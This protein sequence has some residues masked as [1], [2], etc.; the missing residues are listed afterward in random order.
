MGNQTENEGLR[1]ELFSSEGRCSYRVSMCFSSWLRKSDLV[2]L[3][4]MDNGSFVIIKWI[5]N[6]LLRSVEIT[7]I[8]TLRSRKLKDWSKVNWKA[9]HL[10]QKC[11]FNSVNILLSPWLLSLR[12]HH[13]FRWKFWKKGLD[14]FQ[15]WVKM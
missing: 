3:I 14:L 13:R 12:C 1:C 6:I 4:K 5:G 15:F 11:T 7:E 10:V 2:L 9:I 8:R